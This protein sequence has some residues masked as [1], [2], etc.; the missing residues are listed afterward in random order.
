MLKGL[1]FRLRY[2]LV[3]ERAAATDELTDLR[4]ICNYAINF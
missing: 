3:E 1:S 4:L 2:A